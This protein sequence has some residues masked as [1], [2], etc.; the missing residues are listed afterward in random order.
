MKLDRISLG[1]LIRWIT[2]HVFLRRHQNLLDSW[3]FNDPMCRMCKMD[4]ETSD[5][6]ITSCARL[7]EFREFTFGI[8]KDPSQKWEVKSLSDYLLL[9]ADQLETISTEPIDLYVLNSDGQE[10]KIVL[11]PMEETLLY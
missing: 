6:I 5:H 11:E 7:S 1:R 10:M 9:V 8:D 2:G 3:N 4:A